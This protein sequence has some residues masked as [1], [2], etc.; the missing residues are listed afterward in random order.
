MFLGLGIIFF[1]VIFNDRPTCR[2]I[3]PMINFGAIKIDKEMLT[4][5]ES[6]SSHT[7]GTLLV[8]YI[9][10]PCSTPRR[11]VGTSA[12]FHVARTKWRWMSLQNPNCL[13]STGPFWMYS[14]SHFGRTLHSNI[15]S[16][17]IYAV[18]EWDVFQWVIYA[19]MDCGGRVGPS[20]RQGGLA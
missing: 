16:L 1:S 18:L 19:I 20:S 10:A 5:L 3:R 13:S 6:P 9:V 14:D 4:F 7:T 15:S 11:H 17:I 2:L 12:L 8:K